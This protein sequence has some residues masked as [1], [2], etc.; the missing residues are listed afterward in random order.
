M[1]RLVKRATMADVAQYA[2]VT[3][4][5]VSRVL[6]NK[7]EISPETRAR[8]LNAVEVLDTGA[9]VSR[10]ALPPTGRFCSA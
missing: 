1:S 4:T 6:N 8:V 5:T 2:G 3:E 10:A 7:G 9:A